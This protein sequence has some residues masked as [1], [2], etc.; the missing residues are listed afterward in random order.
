MR[1]SCRTT[2]PRRHAV[3]GTAGRRRCGGRATLAEV[4]EA[5]GDCRRC[6]LHRTRQ[7]LVFGEGNPQAELAFV[8][9]APGADEDAQGRP[10]VGRRDS[11]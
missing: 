4:R 11:S 8:G 7:R 2:A 10:F 1:V 6:P 3:R 9:E 5:L